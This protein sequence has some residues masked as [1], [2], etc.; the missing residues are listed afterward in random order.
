MAP[1]KSGGWIIMAEEATPEATNAATDA[2]DASGANS[3][4]SAATEQATEA[5]ETYTKEQL[6]AEVDRRVRSAMDKAEAK[7]IAELEEQ[8]RQ[9]EKMAAIK[10]GEFE[11]AFKQTQAELDQLRS[12]LQA[13]DYKAEAQGVLIK[14]GLSHFGDVLIPGTSTI[15]ELLQRAEAFKK[16]MAE[17]VEQQVKEKLQT[18]IA[19]PTNAEPVKQK[20]LLEMSN[21]E[22]REWKRQKGLV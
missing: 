5:Q 22:F 21:D 3:G 8:Q 9:Q 19:P 7:R 13:K 20:S 1:N 4:Q 12:E 18:P 10:D 11:T 15:D 2:G 6:Q 14:L 16:G 17:G